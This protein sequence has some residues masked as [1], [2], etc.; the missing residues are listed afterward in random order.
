M[1]HLL[2][3][4]DSNT[5]G[6]KDFLALDRF[7]LDVRWTGL[8]AKSLGSNFHIIE[9]GMPGRTTAFDDPM[10]DYRSGRHYLVPC[11]SSHR[12]L[13]L[14]IVMLG[15]N[16]LQ[17]RY[18]ASSTDIATGIEILVDIIKKSGAGPDGGT[19]KIL[20]VA[21]APIG[22]I[23]PVEA[24]CWAGAHKKCSEL[25]ELYRRVADS[26]GCHFVNGQ[27]VLTTEDLGRDGLHFAEGGHA[28]LGKHLAS[29]VAKILQ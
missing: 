2:C 13:D 16:D 18:S 12:P 17:V 11:L 1:Q 9:E 25:P 29:K 10:R 4:G 3:F 22:T 19:P 21:P 26:T 14:V 24:P 15:T 6:T 23:D 27:E 5:F 28:K 8:L 20:I 7:D